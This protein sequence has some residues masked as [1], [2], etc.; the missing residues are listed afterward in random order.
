MK[1]VAL[2][3]LIGF[4]GMSF[5]ISSKAEAEA[6]MKKNGCV[7]CHDFNVKKIGPSFK[8]IAA[9]YK[10]QAGAVDKLVEKV[11][12]GGAGVWGSTPMPPQAVPADQE[13]AFIE[14]ILNNL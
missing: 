11:K 3:A 2:L 14:W 10:G 9:K 13:R 4:A 12:K 5:A 1:K 6:F 8:D 7:A